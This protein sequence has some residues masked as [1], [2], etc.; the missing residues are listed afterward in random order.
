[1]CVLEKKRIQVINSQFRELK[2]KKNK[3]KL[4][5]GR[6]TKTKADVRGIEN[7]N[8]VGEISVDTA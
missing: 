2:R 5:R 1:M 6:A 3:A 8:S 4:G 7:R